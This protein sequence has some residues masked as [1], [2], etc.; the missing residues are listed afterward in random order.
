VPDCI[1]LSE[2]CGFDVSHARSVGSNT[3]IALVMIWL[4][5][6][7]S[8]ASGGR[9][10]WDTA[11]RVG[12]V[13]AGPGFGAPGSGVMH[14]FF[15]W[16]FQNRETGTITIGQAPNRSLWIVIVT[17]ALLWV[18]NP[19][20]RLGVA[21][22]VIF[23]AALFFWAGDEVLS[24]INPWRRCLGIAVLFYGLWTLPR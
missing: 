8:W 5:A 21:L 1:I 12:F 9:S 23:K 7:V 11:R 14:R 17:A 24:G 3:S 19:P 6:L 13:A 16:F 2:V 18:G 20:E 4:I 15:R 10:S 22:E